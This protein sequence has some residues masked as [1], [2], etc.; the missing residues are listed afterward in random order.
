MSSDNSG[1]D[2][3]V[4]IPDPIVSQRKWFGENKPNRNKV[5]RFTGEWIGDE[6]APPTLSDG[7]ISKIN[8]MIAD[9]QN[10]KIELAVS[11]PKAKKQPA[12]SIDPLLMT[13]AALNMKKDKNRF[14]KND[15]KEDK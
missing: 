6:S 4:P 15:P 8:D 7:D 12:K 14:V 1:V 11:E 5:L 2:K 10:P 13:L 3:N 9:G